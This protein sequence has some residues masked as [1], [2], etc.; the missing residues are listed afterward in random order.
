ML[1]LVLPLSSCSERAPGCPPLA[2]LALIVVYTTPAVLT[3][4]GATSP[5]SP[6]MTARGGGTVPEG[7]RLNDATPERS[8]ADSGSLN[9]RP[10]QG[11]PVSSTLDAC[12]RSWPFDAW[13]LWALLVTGGVYLRGWDALRRHGRRWHGGHLTA[14][15]GVLG[16]CV[17]PLRG[18]VAAPRGAPFFL[19]VGLLL[20]LYT[21]Y[22]LAPTPKVLAPWALLMVLLFAGG[23]W[24]LFQPMQMRGTVL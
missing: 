22:R 15:L 14:F 4:Q 9:P 21:G 18:G 2:G 8:A 3:Y 17:L 10:L 11:I 12:L 16:R 1:F 24:I 13:L 5:C 23:V 20:S 7:G 6:K 19:D